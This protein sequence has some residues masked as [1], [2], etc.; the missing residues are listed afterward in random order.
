MIDPDADEHGSSHWRGGSAALRLADPLLLYLYLS[1][2]PLAILAPEDRN[3][4]LDTLSALHPRGATIAV[5][6]DIR[7]RFWENA[8]TARDAI[9]LAAPVSDFLLPSFDNGRTYFG[10]SDPS[11]IAARR[12]AAGAGTVIFTQ[13]S[14]SILTPDADGERVHP[15]GAPHG[16]AS[17]AAVGSSFNAHFLA[18][19]VTRR[20]IAS[21]GVAGSPPM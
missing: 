11:E 12:G 6:S 4:R 19:H 7:P 2:I 9:V 15:V 13:G 1:R 3:K 16:I 17:A 20:R 8:A 21:R 18:T 5:H 10:A 14:E